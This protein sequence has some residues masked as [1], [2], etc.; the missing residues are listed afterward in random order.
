MRI[1]FV[2]QKSI[3][4]LLALMALNLSLVFA[5]SGRKNT[6]EKRFDLD[7]SWLK[8]LQ[9]KRDSPVKPELLL[10]DDSQSD[11]LQLG[12][13]FEIEP[14][15]HLYWLNPGV[16][17]LPPQVRWELPEGFAE[18]RLIFPA[19][20]KFFSSGYLVYG[21]KEELLLIG[22]IGKPKNILIHNER[23]LLLKA[24]LNWMVCRESCL[25]GEEEV[26]INLS[27][28]DPEKKKKAEV[29]WKRFKDKFPRSAEEINVSLKEAKIIKTEP[30]NPLS[31]I[32]L[33]LNLEGQDLF[34][35]VDFYPLPIE[36]FILEAE[37]TKYGNGLVE[38][39]LRPVISEAKIKEITGLL[40]SQ[41]FCFLIKFLLNEQIINQK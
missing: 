33:S 31:E 30:A 39:Y 13:Y 18:L 40:I 5:L 3:L 2:S 1:N 8:P 38:L 36:D 14:G 27:S 34:R 12:I 29:I 7:K 41:N 23:P 10:L 28:I 16:A 11:Y 9:E 25:V 24:K 4:L 26:V 20:S 15:W 21:Y 37:K 6:L 22:H 19:P 32:L 35:I 17:G